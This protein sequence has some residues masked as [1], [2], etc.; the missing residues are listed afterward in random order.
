[1]IYLAKELLPKLK[2]LMLAGQKASG[3]LEWIG[4]KKT[5]DKVEAEIK[6]HA[7]DN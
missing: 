7:N 1:M 6:K 4:D 5:W 2:Y 3:E